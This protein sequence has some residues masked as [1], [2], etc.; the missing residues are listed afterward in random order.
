MLLEISMALLEVPRGTLLLSLFLHGFVIEAS[1]ERQSDEKVIASLRKTLASARDA[2]DPSAFFLD[3][4][5]VHVS[6]G[7]AESAFPFKTSPSRFPHYP[8]L[9]GS[10][11]IKAFFE[12][13]AKAHVTLK[14]PYEESGEYA[15]QMFV[16]SDT[17]VTLTGKFGCRA[18][19]GQVLSQAWVRKGDAWK[20]RS[21]MYKIDEAHTSLLQFQETVPAKTDEASLKVASEPSVSPVPPGSVTKVAGGGGG[22]TWVLIVL[23]VVFVLALLFF[24]KRRRRKAAQWSS[25]NAGGDIWLG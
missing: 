7:P 22:P 4:A 20:V 9:R 15:P 19:S 23:A 6:L 12:G 5:A 14:H 8:T 17:E 18:M 13:V 11:E 2:S 25:I 24:E 3:D 10:E 1:I 21:A 16:V